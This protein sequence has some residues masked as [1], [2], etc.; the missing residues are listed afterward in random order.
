MHVEWVFSDTRRLDCIWIDVNVGIAASFYTE[1]FVHQMIRFLALGSPFSTCV[2]LLYSATLLE[3]WI[4]FSLIIRKFVSWFSHLLCFFV[5]ATRL[6]LYHVIYKICVDEG[7]GATRL[8]CI[9]FL[10][11][12][13]SSSA[14]S[15]AQTDAPIIG[16]VL[17]DVLMHLGT[18]HC[19]FC[20]TNIVRKCICVQ[21]LVLIYWL[22]CLGVLGVANPSAIASNLG[23]DVGKSN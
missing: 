7:W 16:V 10:P 6:Q 21:C 13:A 22:R 18:L 1:R 2:V 9:K 19:A 17:V 15:N 23:P 8:R 11:T 5:L 20:I 3:L 4:C 14:P 12:S